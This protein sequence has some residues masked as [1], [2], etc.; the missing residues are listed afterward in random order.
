[1]TPPALARALLRRLLPRHEIGDSLE[2]DLEEGFVRRA[3]ESRARARWWYRWQVLTLP[4]ARL[5]REVARL[6][7][8]RSR[9]R[10][11]TGG[12][13]VNAR[14]M[15][16]SIAVRS[17]VRRPGFTGVALAT[18]S[19]SIGAATLLFSVVDGVLLSPLPYERPDE[20]V[21]VYRTSDEWR[22]GD[23]ELFRNSWNVLPMTQA[24][25]EAFRAAPGPITGVTAYTYQTLP[26]ESG[27]GAATK[28]DAILVDAEAFSVL[29]V[30]PFM[31]R[32]PTAEEVRQEAP[33]AVLRYETWIARFGG[34][35]DVIGR[36]F[37]LGGRADRALT[38]IGVMPRGFFFPTES[39][40]LWTPIHG[41]ARDWPSFWAV[42][43]MAPEASV[44]E[45]TAFFER[46]SRRLG[47]EDPG[48]AGQGGRAV[49]H[50]DSVVGSVRGGIQLLFGTALLVVLAACTNVGNLLFART[51]GRR[52]ELAVRASLG[53]GAGSLASTVL[54]EV[55]VIGLVGGGLG[56]LLAG[57][58]L[59]PF[60]E[61]LES[62]LRSLPRGGEI[63]L[64]GS[65]LLFSTGATLTTMVVAG[66][67]PVV[68]SARRAQAGG[69]GNR[70]RSGAGRSTRR[71][72]RFLLSV[73]GALTVVLVL[74]A[75][76]MVRSFLAAANVGT[77]MVTDRV[78]VLEV[79]LDRDRNLESTMLTEV[80]EA[81]RSRVAALPAVASVGL[82]SSLTGHGGALIHDV[83]REGADSAD[84]AAVIA[85]TV[86]EGYFTALGIR[87][88]AGRGFRGTDG[89]GDVAEVVVSE[90]LAL[91]VFGR[92]SVVG[93]RLLM[94]GEVLRIIGVVD[95]TRQ[96]SVFQDP[97]ASLYYPLA[98]RPGYGRHFYVGMAVDGDPVSVLQAARD[99]VLAVNETLEVEQAST[100]PQ[101]LG[102]S[103]RHIRM[104]MILMAALALIAGVLAMVGISGVVAHFLSEQTRDVGIRMAL[105]A[106]AGREVGRVVRQAFVPTVVG[107]AV[108]V[109]V[110]L[111][112][113]TVMR[114]FLF[115]IEPIDPLTYLGVT[116]LLLATALLAAWIPARRTAA[117]DPVRVL[118]S[119]V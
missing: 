50:G 108:G 106:A 83:R 76:L 82:A 72:Q 36:A 51:A 21:T 90:S 22:T 29:G 13:W 58:A 88:L 70:Q 42:A 66:L 73:Q 2:G 74:A 84:A 16:L 95:E 14:W 68:K 4:Y 91:Q 34:D 89:K 44:D 101:M 69:V 47:E 113:S 112:A 1:M 85:V 57:A 94:G 119:E 15:D 3:A 26:L 81:V 118:K 75:A 114:S 62:S 78:A 86:G 102:D 115:G 17:L 67:G 20:L 56:V 65:V 79:H 46:V 117:V 27:D 39:A 10:L 107:V 105:G 116:G 33:V 100:F 92:T 28:A 64:H 61:A 35:P 48:Q 19:L 30:A 7:A 96:L 45:A 23:N 8:R 37:R 41:E 11:R 109:G 59:G 110:A 80:H 63:G 60:V 40:A 104:R 71:S 38:V 6:E 111:P 54:A 87:V 32:L 25:V 77:G 9:S 55:L 18:L 98:K 99:A 53:A 31:G 52:E 43:R 103:M 24:L 5:H 12:G 93:D 49:P 97:T